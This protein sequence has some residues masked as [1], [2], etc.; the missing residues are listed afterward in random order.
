MATLAVLVVLATLTK[1]SEEPPTLALQLAMASVHNSY[2]LIRSVLASP[3]EGA[4]E[5]TTMEESS[6]LGSASRTILIK[7]TATLALIQKHLIQ[8]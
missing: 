6:N 2:G 4:R 3:L 1:S 7:T 8:D 5:L